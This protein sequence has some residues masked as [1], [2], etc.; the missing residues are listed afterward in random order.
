[1]VSFSYVNPLSEGKAHENGGTTKDFTKTSK[2]TD[3]I[4]STIVPN[5]TWRRCGVFS[6]LQELVKYPDLILKWKIIGSMRDAAEL[7]PTSRLRK[8]MPPKAP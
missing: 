4:W 5:T 7:L 8:E 1:M 6:F 3:R 2:T